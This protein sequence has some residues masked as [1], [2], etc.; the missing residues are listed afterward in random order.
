LRGKIDMGQYRHPTTAEM[1][2]VYC[3]KNGL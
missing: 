3:W 2:F 1:L